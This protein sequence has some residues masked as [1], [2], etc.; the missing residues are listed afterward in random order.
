MTEQL[1][2]DVRVK[3]PEVS[4]EGRRPDGDAAW[5]EQAGGG[6][7]MG[8]GSGPCLIYLNSKRKGTG[9]SGDLG[10]WLWE[11]KD[12]LYSLMYSELYLHPLAEPLN[13]YH[14]LSF[15]WL[16]WSHLPS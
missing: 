3:A 12:S 16:Q 11:G 5:S 7:Y 13:R 6:N 10:F 1:S 4:L 14:C 2:T 15:F 8:V 9:S